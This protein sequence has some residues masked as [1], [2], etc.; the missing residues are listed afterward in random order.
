MTEKL[1]YEIINPSDP[2]TIL[3]PSFEAATVATLLL[4]RGQ[5]AAQPVDHEGEEVPL[6]LFGGFEAWF[7]KRFGR[8]EDELGAFIVE[9]R[10]D[11]IETLRSACTGKATDRKLFDAAL[12]AI[13]DDEKRKAFLAEWDDKKRSSINAIANRSHAMA[14]SLAAAQAESETAPA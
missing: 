10:R 6:F 4:G 2:V 3:A 9:H 13:T 11:T 14:E 8:K 1:L 12:A 5:Y 7:E